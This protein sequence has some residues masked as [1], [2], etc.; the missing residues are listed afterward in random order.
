MNYTS[1][2]VRNS[3]ADF[4]DLLVIPNPF[5]KFINNG[6]SIEK[7]PTG[8]EIVCFH[9]DV[10]YDED[11]YTCERCGSRMHVHDVYKC[12]LR[13]VCLGEKPS[14]VMFDKHRFECPVCGHMHM[15]RVLFKAENHRITNELLAQVENLLARGYNN[16]QVAELTNLGQGTVKE[17]D[18]ERL[19]RLYTENGKLKRPSKTTKYIAIDEFKLHD[20]NKYATH[21][22]DLENGH[23]IWIQEGKKKQVVYDFMEFVGEEWMKHVI[24]VACDMNSDFEEAFKERCPHIKPVFDRF[25]IVKNFNEKVISE[26]RKDE[27]QRLIDEGDEEAARH[28]KHSK[29]ILMSNRSTLKRKDAEAL[30]GK[31]IHEGSSIFGTHSV[32]RKG[33]YQEKY[34]QLISENK[35]LF[36]ADLVKEMLSDAYECTSSIRMAEILDK[37][38][39]TCQGA[40]NKHFNWF[41]DLLVRHYDGIVAHADIPISSGKIE[42]LN[43]KIKTV[44][45]NAYGIPDDEYFFLKVIDASNKE[46]VRNPKTHKISH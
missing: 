27:Q 11:D 28:L 43:N 38:I 7:T 39:E 8:V 6:T 25:H 37:I 21:I 13:H 18:K 46:Y 33:G 15:Q 2:R 23:V 20:G 3:S 36:T 14:V 41:A 42:G 44:R 26:I 5:K 29:Y 24:G 16:K 30:N 19:K 12:T 35:L 1:D 45:R 32:T 31:V 34:E 9:G 10:Y 4:P 17:I 22:I 40:L